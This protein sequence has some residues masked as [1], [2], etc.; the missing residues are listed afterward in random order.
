MIRPSRAEVVT[1]FA[2]DLAAV[3]LAF[4]GAYVARFELRWLELIPAATP[5]PTDYVRALAVAVGVIFLVLHARG[6]YSDLPPRGFDVFERTVTAATIALVVLLGMSFFYREFSYSRSVSLLAWAALVALLP[7]P[8]LSLLL[9]RRRAYAQGRRLRPA[10][11]VGTSSASLALFDRLV[12]HR[13]YGLAVRGLLAL[14]GPAAGDEGDPPNADRPDGDPEPSGRVVGHADALEEIA[15]RLGVREL[16]IPDVL[17]RL[18]L[19]ELL[20]R[21]ERIGVEPRIVPNVFDLFIVPGDLSELHGVPFVSVREQR[22][23]R[24]SLAL[25]RLFDATVASV[26]LLVAT[27]LLALLVLLIRRESSGPAFFAQRRVGQ[28][29]RIFWMWKLR[30]MVEDAHERLAD[31]VD[32]DA[33][34]Q[35]VFK[36]DADPRVT[37]VGRWLRRWSLD[38][39]PQLW[40]VVRGD[41]SLVGP[42]PEVENVVARYDAHHRRRL[43]AKPGLTGLQQIVARASTD[44]DERVRLD[45]YYIRRRT[46]LYD[47]W[48]LLRTPWAVV[49]GKG[50]R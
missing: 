23:E 32:L 11:I 12:G 15:A 47:L 2:S 19:L 43:K 8:R 42:R 48:L 36:L 24:L 34:D 20:E 39:L 9:L 21:C 44:L 41:M 17:E 3:A 46:F 30:S 4:W 6:L 26:L 7:L 18:A 22:F 40:N 29:G 28:N 38:E 10:L 16:L 13:D 45:V 31:V 35:P 27:P 49:R 5:A 33:L 25:K 1:L 37:G 50:A 14:D